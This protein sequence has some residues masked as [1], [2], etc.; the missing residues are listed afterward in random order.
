MSRLTGDGLTIA[1]SWDLPVA[2]ERIAE[3]PDYFVALSDAKKALL[4]IDKK[5]LAIRRAIMMDYFRRHDVALHPT[6][7]WAYVSA[8]VNKGGDLIDSFMI[9]DENTGDVQEPEGLVGTWLAF[10]RDGK[11]LYVGEK[12]YRFNSSFDSLASYDIREVMRP[13]TRNIK[14][15]PGANG[16]G[17]VLSPDGKRVS[18]LT[19]TGYPLYSKNVAA[20]DTGDLEKR[21]VIYPCKENG[22]SCFW[23]AF[24]PQAKLAAVP[25]ETGGV[26][27]FDRETGEPIPNAVDLAYPTLGEVT[28]D[29]LYFS[30]DG[31]N[32]LLECI[33]AEGRFLRR[34]PLT[35]VPK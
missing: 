25:I 15:E 31:R 28:V 29:R 21:P 5:T 7:P 32:I 9:V 16:R 30:P 24:H 27:C 23:I 17:L 4:L 11:S 10:S 3:R 12:Q 26:V 22:A 8:S 14:Y 19:F 2:C 1:Q 35:R 34:A 20:W 6:K 18:Y 33:G 13:Y